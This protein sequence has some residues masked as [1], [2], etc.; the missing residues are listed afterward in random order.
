MA[1]RTFL[2][3]QFWT[4]RYGLTK[5]TSIV[6]LKKS[7]VNGPKYHKISHSSSMT[8]TAIPQLA[9]YLSLEGLVQCLPNKQHTHTTKVLD[10]S[11]IHHHTHSYT[12]VKPMK[13]HPAETHTRPQQKD[14]Q[15]VE[16]M[17]HAG[18]TCTRHRPPD[19]NFR[20]CTNARD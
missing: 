18:R 13:M 9:T 8:P 7:H 20:S 6:A 5:Y 12:N 19:L 11:A 14:H 10:W 1:T 17:P 15:I 3:G 4:A 2:S 16:R